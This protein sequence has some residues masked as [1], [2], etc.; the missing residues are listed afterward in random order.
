MHALFLFLRFAAKKQKKRKRSENEGG[1]KG[2]KRGEMSEKERKRG[3]GRD[4]Q[5]AHF[6]R[7]SFEAEWPVCC[8]SSGSSS[9]EAIETWY[10]SPGD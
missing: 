9:S 1:M 7:P 6:L 8:H 3:R 2:K 4:I 10:S 5:D